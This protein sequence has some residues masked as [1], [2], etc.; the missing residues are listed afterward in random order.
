VRL[1]VVVGLVA[2]AAVRRQCLPLRRRAVLRILSPEKWNVLF[3]A[4][5]CNFDLKTAIL[6]FD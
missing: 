1:L 6:Y 4:N 3:W 5:I 2:E